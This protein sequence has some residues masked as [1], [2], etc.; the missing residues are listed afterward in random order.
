MGLLAVDY[1]GAGETITS[2]GPAFPSPHPA[3]IEAVLEGSTA[4]LYSRPKLQSTILRVAT[5]SSKVCASR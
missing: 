5:F 4:L 1:N 3:P 2:V